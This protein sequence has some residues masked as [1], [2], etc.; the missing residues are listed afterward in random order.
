MRYRLIGL[1]CGLAMLVGAGLV[2]AAPPVDPALTGYWSG[3]EVSGLRVFD[4]SGQERSGYRYGN[5]TQV[6][7]RV[8]RA[9][10]FERGDTVEVGPGT[11][12][13]PGGSFS[14]EFWVLCGVQKTNFPMFDWGS[15]ADS[16]D[17][18][19]DPPAGMNLR[20]A[21]FKAYDHVTGQVMQPDTWQHVVWTYD[22]KLTEKALKVYVNGE[23]KQSW[24]EAGKLGVSKKPLIIGQ[25]AALDE[26][27]MYKRALTP[28]EIAAHATAPEAVSG[29]QVVISEVWPAKLF[30]R[31]GQKVKLQVGV[32]SVSA[33]PQ[34]VTLKAF[35]EAGL[36][37][38]LPLQEAPLTLAP[39][40]VKELSFDWDPGANLYGFDLVA[41]LRDAQGQLL[42]RKS[43]SFLVGKNPYQLGQYAGYAS[44][45]WDQD[46]VISARRHAVMMRSH[47]IPLSEYWAFNA[48]TFGKCV[49]DTDKWFVG[50]GAT[51][52]RLDNAT[53]EALMT[54][55]HELGLGVVPYS[56]SYVSG[57]YGTKLALEHPEWMAYDRKGRITGGVETE[58]DELMTRFYNEYPGSLDDK[59]L[60]AAINRFPNEGAGLQISTVNLANRD[61]IKYHAESVA[62]GVQHFNFDGLRWDGHP[63]VGGPGDPITMGV[64]EL[65]DL[66]GK[67]LVP[68]TTER[69]RLSVENT[70]LVKSLVLKV[71]PDA[72][73]GYNWGLE[74]QKHGRIRPTDYAECCRDGGT[75]LW[76]SVNSIHDPGSPWHRW[77]DAADM[78]ADEVE[79]PRQNGGF[80]QVG[81][82]PWWLAGEVYGKHLLSAIFAARARL[83]NAPGIE[84]NAPYLHF[85][86]RYADLLYDASVARSPE[87]AAATKVSS[88]QVWWQ[89][90]VF[91]RPAP[92]G[93]QIIVHLLNSPASEF[94]EIG[95]TTP[96]TLL[97]DVQV[98]FALPGG[99]A[100]KAVYLLSPDRLPLRTPLPA[101]PQGG[102]LTV[103]VPELLYWD[104]LVLQF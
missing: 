87:W 81:A 76:E 9:L 90:Y 62:A 14:I 60:M 73:F 16:F 24:D 12:L 96:P 32:A 48:D 22:E 11:G 2:A 43:E 101:T 82:F 88:P 6:P 69:D 27:R 80:L 104:T 93:K 10:Q 77:Q 91:E 37:R 103:T 1:V 44:Y 47:Y 99:Q 36:G 56:L 31:P 61:A 46:S 15:I 45:T 98:S 5:P 8:G 78:I 50:S 89:K 35:V 100:P 86:A 13:G 18:Y 68:N 23:L 52:Y 39:G 42:D 63:Q 38:E 72:V 49:P 71:N 94:V 25:G 84:T 51:A 20:L 70:R 34:T 75:I 30:T 17:L 97:K 33:T 74:Y 95:S 29:R 58:L 3:D 57:Y 26:I 41:E 92:E 40:E 83:F 21:G 79:C 67:P 4:A 54:S 19:F 102:N 55:C 65:F 85:A 28:E 53:T 59:D 66:Q 7:G 64:P